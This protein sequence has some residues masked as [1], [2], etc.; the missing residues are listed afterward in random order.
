MTGVQT[1]ALPISDY[2]YRGSSD[3]AYEE[4]FNQAKSSSGSSLPALS[5]K[6]TD[7]FRRIV[8]IGYRGLAKEY[9]PD[10]TKDNGED[11]K[12]L[13]GLA[14]KLRSTGWL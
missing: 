8:Q 1:C 6:E 2:S 12:R 4:F 14:A 13:N 5:Q 7:D 9:H 10:I 3:R 11:M